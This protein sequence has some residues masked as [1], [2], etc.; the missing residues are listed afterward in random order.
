M[1]PRRS[2]Y[3]TVVLLGVLSACATT[4]TGSSVPAPSLRQE[5]EEGRAA[6]FLNAASSL[7]LGY[8][9]QE[10]LL[11]AGQMVRARSEKVSAARR[12]LLILLADGIEAGT[13]DDAKIAA[14]L[15][16]IS[17]TAQA[18]D[19][20]VVQALIQLHAFLSTPE[21][22]SMA[23]TIQ[24]GIAASASRFKKEPDQIRQRVDSVTNQVGLTAEQS[25]QINQEIVVNYQT[26]APDLKE[27]ADARTKQLDLLCKGFV[28]IYFQPTLESVVAAPE[29]VAKS[30]RTIALIRQLTVILTPAQRAK[31][32]A[33]IRERNNLDDPT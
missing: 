8:Q 33:V 19:P 15:Q 14:G 11:N 28:D 12:G 20:A 6:W 16:T 24:Q 1:T 2:R 32:A 22:E 25:A 10:Q 18:R 13:F 29:L 26:Y 3:L 27:E 23:S 31:V 5:L 30:T 21:R 17:A 4:P 7:K 9:Q